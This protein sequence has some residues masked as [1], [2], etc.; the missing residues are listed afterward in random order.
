LGLQQR[1]SAPKRMLKGR[2]FEPSVAFLQQKLY[3]RKLSVGAYNIPRRTCYQ[4][5][6]EMD[7]LNFLLL[8][9]GMCVV[10]RRTRHF[11]QLRNAASKQKNINYLSKFGNG[12]IVFNQYCLEN[13]FKFICVFSAMPFYV[14]S[15][16]LFVQAWGSLRSNLTH[17]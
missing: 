1:Q 14:L 16:F 7:S 15:M 12:E 9:L 10:F 4:R 17:L 6:F 8:F 5:S 2:L 13:S 11:T 3:P